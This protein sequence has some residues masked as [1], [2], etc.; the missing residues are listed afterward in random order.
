M[1]SYDKWPDF[2]ADEKWPD[3]DSG[4]CMNWACLFAVLVHVKLASYVLYS[5]TTQ[6]KKI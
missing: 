1:E 3:P 4:R 2:D 6:D 5:K